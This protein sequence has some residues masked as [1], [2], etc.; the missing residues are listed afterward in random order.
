MEGGNPSKTE[1]PVTMGVCFFDHWSPHESGRAG[2]EDELR[3]LASACVPNLFV[4][5]R[6]RTSLSV[7]QERMRR[8]K[9]CRFEATTR[10]AQEILWRTTTKC[11][12]R[13]QGVIINIKKSCW[14]KIEGRLQN[15]MQ[16]DPEINRF[17]RGILTIGIRVAT[18]DPFHV[19]TRVCRYSRFAINFVIW[20]GM[21]LAS[22][23][24]E[25][26]VQNASAGLLLGAS[27]PS[28][29][30][31]GVPFLRSVCK[32]IFT[33]LNLKPTNPPAI[34]FWSPQTI[35]NE[36]SSPFCVDLWKN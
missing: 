36:E 19:S 20:R 24:L 31:L 9:L 29:G 17:T 27:R 32:Q 8:Q 23:F 34:E 6:F 35:A 2:F 25:L 10:R 4:F 15:E 26:C 30:A 33:L 14:H 5:Q 7:A 13:S 18:A 21:P 22:V 28:V 11:R 12:A 3:N 16:R 1:V